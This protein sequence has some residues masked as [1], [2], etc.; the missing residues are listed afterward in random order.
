[1]HGGITDLTSREVLEYRDAAGNKILLQQ[2]IHIIQRHERT[3]KV[4]ALIPSQ[5]MQNGLPEG[6]LL[7][8]MLDINQ[9]Q[10]KLQTLFFIL[11][12]GL[13]LSPG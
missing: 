4:E 13:Y 7:G 2:A 9:L 12:R 10:K 8:R 1:M 3:R 11:S 5:A 6:D